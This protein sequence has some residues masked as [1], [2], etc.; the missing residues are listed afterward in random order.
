MDLTAYLYPLRKWWWLILIAALIAGISS[1]V[2][3][4]EMPQIYEAHAS[5]LVGRSI[6][7]PNPTDFGLSVGRQLANFYAEIAS[8][9]PVRRAVE[10]ELGLDVLPTYETRVPP[11]T[12][13][14]EIS[15]RD[16][17][18][19]RAVAVANSL[20]NQIIARSPTESLED[21]ERRSF[22]QDQLNSLEEDIQVTQAELADAQDK[23][24]QLTS[25]V[26]IAE[27]DRQIGALTTKLITLQSNYATL[28]SSS[29]Q[30][31]ENTV[32]LIEPAE[33]PEDP[34][35]P[36]RSLLVGLAI[37][38]GLVLAVATSFLFEATNKTI[39][40]PEVLNQATNLPVMASIGK[41]RNKGPLVTLT[42][43]QSQEA[44]SFRL[45]RAE[46]LY[47]P[48]A[49]GIR[50]LLLTSSNPEEGKSAIAANL[51]VAIAQAGNSVLLIDADL[52][53][54]KQHEIFGLPNEQ[55][56]STLLLEL[57]EE[58][59]RINRRNIISSFIPQHT[60]LKNLN[61]VTAGPTVSGASDLLVSS[62]L[63]EVV[64]G[65]NREY[66]YTIYDSPAVLAK[67]D[68]IV[69]SQNVEGVIFIVEAGM[70]QRDDIH[71]AIDSLQS[72]EANLIG[73]VL[74]RYKTMSGAHAYYIKKIPSLE[75][76]SAPAP[77]NPGLEE[78]EL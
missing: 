64:N 45:L 26:E 24:G 12:Q 38:I 46:V 52:H 36:S 14:I 28:L 60:E 65:L 17:D 20:A 30:G 75:Q 72:V 5:L 51:A 37:I 22:I 8:R 1:F 49:K 56:L 43:P 74:N 68:G 54:P 41:F 47:A 3:T 61:I 11:G 25:A 78:T 71:Q 23:F 55:G 31:S 73:S 69:L 33:L 39:N 58:D 18:P 4:Q 76:A 9:E 35:S 48:E 10:E 34:I 29:S 50:N 6:E 27:A 67:V 21:L 2:A 62:D 59:S 15:V 42:E 7:N 77:V 53:I 70:T 32:R 63:V 16:V 13:V 40:S 66:E 19:E 44:E 57:S